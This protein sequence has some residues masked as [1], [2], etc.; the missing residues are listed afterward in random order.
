MHRQT[1]THTSGAGS[2]ASLARA[3]PP[4]PAHIAAS[5]DAVHSGLLVEGGSCSRRRIR[6]ESANRGWRDGWL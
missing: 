5:A 4:K 6:A 3:V 2:R 1:Q